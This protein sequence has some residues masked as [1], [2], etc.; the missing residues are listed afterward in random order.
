MEWLYLDSSVFGGYYDK[1][2]TKWSKALIDTIIREDDYHIIFS[3][4]LDGELADAPE[5]VKNLALDI[6]GNKTYFVALEDSAIAL[7][8]AYIEDGVVGKTSRADCLHIALATLNNADVLVSWNF[9]HIVN[10]KKIRGYNAVNYKFGY[11]ILDIRT[12]R[13]ILGDAE[14]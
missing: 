10:Y 14:K 3:E 4:V 11:K 13:E 5:Q 7:A 8:D 1:E 9:N 6:P 12:P 2:F